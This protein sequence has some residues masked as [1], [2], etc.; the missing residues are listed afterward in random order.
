MSAPNLRRKLYSE[1]KATYEKKGLKLK[2]TGR[3]KMYNKGKVTDGKNVG[4]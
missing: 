3:K 1:E 4:K 2:I